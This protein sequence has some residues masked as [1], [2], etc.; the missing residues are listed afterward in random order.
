MSGTVDRGVSVPLTVVVLTLNEER[1]LPACLESVVGWATE[2]FVV[3]SGSTDATGAI[4]GRFGARVVTHAFETHAR[5]WK[6]ALDELPIQTD[7]VLGLDADQRV[8]PELQQEISRRL[9]RTTT[10]HA[11]SGYFVRR[12]Q[13]FRGRWIRHGGYYPKDLLKLF[14]LRAVSVDETDLVDH[15]FIVSGQTEKIPFDIIEDNRNETAIA[16][17]TARHNHYAVLQ[18]RQELRAIG[19]DAEVDLGL[20][21]RAPDARIRWLKRI[22]RHLP[23]FVRPCLYFV[24]RYVFRLG[25]L[26]GK[27]GFIFHVLQAFWY[28]LLVDVNLEEER[29]A[30]T[31]QPDAASGGPMKP[32]RDPAAGSDTDLE[33]A[34]LN[35]TPPSR[36]AASGI[37]HMP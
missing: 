35:A 13:I 12:R 2:V 37:E 26:D 23:L 7:W 3:D 18:A 30:A 15:H 10:A 28:R 16:V 32:V 19:D 8:T 17:W 5:Q 27:E 33:E 9:S 36:R 21:F 34:R 1:N 29:A 11:S 31:R 25:F 4:A 20:I 24:Y 14:R 22:W 6:W